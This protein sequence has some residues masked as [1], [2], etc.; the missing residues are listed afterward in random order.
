MGKHLDANEIALVEAAARNRMTAKDVL[1]QI[2]KA[3]EKAKMDPATIN[4][5]RRVLRGET[6]H[7][8]RVETRGRKRVLKKKDKTRLEKF[9]VYL[10]KKAKTETRVSYEQIIAAAGLQGEVSEKTV[11]KYFNNELK[12]KWRPARTKPDRT[13]EE[14]KKREEQAKRWA[15]K[16]ESFWKDSVHGYLDNKTFAVPCSPAKKALI[17]RTKVTGHLRKRS[18]GTE[19]HCVRPKTQGTFIGGPS[20]VIAACVSPQT[21]RFVMFHEI[22]FDI[23][24][25]KKW[26]GDYAQRMYEGP[27]KNAM[28]RSYGKLNK[29]FIVEDGDPTGYQS[30]AGK[31][32]KKNAGIV[33]LKLPPRT[34]SWMP[35]DFSLWKEI[36]KRALKGNNKVDT[37]KTWVQQLRKAAHGLSTAYVKRCCGSL[38]KRIKA[39]LA[40]KGKHE[41][42][43]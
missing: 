20:V 7:R 25:Q 21:G 27:L 42:N 43:D 35:L 28:V 29:Y 8:A 3:R 37:K 22:K 33:S 13:A 18:E 30:S 24:N 17:R 6:F 12:V 23:P 16:P 19:K 32:G 14:E 4:S 10:L 31:A 5:V 1:A 34:P 9:R 11:R 41:K 36:Q 15:R 39:T 38:K 40:V 2:N 26:S